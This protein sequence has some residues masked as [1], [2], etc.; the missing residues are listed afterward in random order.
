MFQDRN[1]SKN[2]NTRRVEADVKWYNPEKG[3]G[4]LYTGDNSGD[5]MIHFSVLDKVSCPYVKAGDRVVCDVGFGKLGLQVIR[6]IEVK[7]ESSEPRTLSAFLDSQM[8]S[9]D[10]DSLEEVRGTLKWYNSKKGY[11]FIYPDDGRGEIFLHASVLR[12]AGYKFLE[13]GTHVLAKIS[14]STRGEEA[15]LIK[16]IREERKLEEVGS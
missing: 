14:Q 10:P 16:V 12:A 8:P 3:Y 9:F 5:I 2:N 4:F 13:P 1:I 15:R 11:G 6:V 7:F